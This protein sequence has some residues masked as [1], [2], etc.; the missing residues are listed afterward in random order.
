MNYGEIFQ[1][2]VL[3]LFV[4]FLVWANYRDRNTLRGS[5]WPRDEP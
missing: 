1:A 5:W 2:S 4:G 3:V